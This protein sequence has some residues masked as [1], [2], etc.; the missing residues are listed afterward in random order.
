[1]TFR[2]R[3]AGFSSAC[4]ASCLQHMLET[5]WS[6]T[7]RATQITHDCAHERAASSSR[8]EVYVRKM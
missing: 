2:H 7:A 3:Q 4:C 8:R 1:M 6:V 5:S